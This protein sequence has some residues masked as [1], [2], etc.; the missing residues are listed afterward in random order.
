MT[1]AMM[2][3]ASSF[4]STNSR[5]VTVCGDTQTAQVSTSVTKLADGRES[6]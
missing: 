3:G 6:V 4:I 5:L 1:I 2:T